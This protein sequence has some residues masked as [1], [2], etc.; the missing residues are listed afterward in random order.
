MITYSFKDAESSPVFGIKD[1]VLFF[2]PLKRWYV[3]LVSVKEFFEL[4]IDVIGSIYLLLLFSTH[5]W[6]NY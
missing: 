1:S 5:L 6:Y 3:N 4:I 2:S